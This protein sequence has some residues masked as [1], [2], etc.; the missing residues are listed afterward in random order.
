MAKNKTVDCV[1]MPYCN[2]QKDL[3]MN[4]CDNCQFYKMI[5][6]GY[7]YCI[8]LPIASTVAWCKTPCALFKE[9]KENAQN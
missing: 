9:I 3:S 4:T 5:D 6:S 2:C 1:H 7:G 8:A